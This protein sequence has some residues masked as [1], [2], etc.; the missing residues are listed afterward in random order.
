MLRMEVIFISKIAGGV[1]LGSS[2]GYTTQEKV[3]IKKNLYQ[4]LYFSNFDKGQFVPLGNCLSNNKNKGFKKKASSIQIIVL[5]RQIM[6][7]V[8]GGAKKS[9]Q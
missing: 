8:G 4:I 1:Q 3:S 2:K 5:A 6:G 7:K 9:Q